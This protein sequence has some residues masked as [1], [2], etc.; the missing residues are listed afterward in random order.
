LQQH[1][2]PMEVYR[3][4]CNLFV[5]TFIGSPAM[6]ITTA[7]IAVS[8]GGLACRVGDQIVELPANVVAAGNAARVRGMG[9]VVFGVRPADLLVGAERELR[10]NGRV[11]LVEPVGPITYVDVEVGGWAVTAMADPD[12]PIA[13]G[14]TVTLGFSPSRVRLFDQSSEARL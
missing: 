13:V 8:G 3:N 14:D 1:G 7:E 10:L 2:R 11:F 9:R 6:N 4:P 12:Q 5:A